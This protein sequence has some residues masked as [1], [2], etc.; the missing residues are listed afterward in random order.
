LLLFLIHHFLTEYPA[1]HQFA[2]PEIVLRIFCIAL[3]IF[4]FNHR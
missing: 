3:T 2:E 4:L 1:Q